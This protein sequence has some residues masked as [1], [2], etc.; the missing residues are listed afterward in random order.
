MPPVPPSDA[1]RGFTLLE[2]LVAVAILG[3][4]LT[5]ILSS[6]VGLFASASRG[7]HITVATN[8]A[9][10][11]MSELEVD[12]L[13]KGYPVT[14]MH[15]EGRCCG[16]DSEPGYDCAWKIERVKLP[17]QTLDGG[18]DASLGPLGALADIG[19]SK[20]RAGGPGSPG[21]NPLSALTALS[22]PMGSDGGPPTLQG[23]AQSLGSASS[24]GSGLGPMVMGMVYPSLKPM[25]EASIRK[26]SVQVKWKEGIK[27]KELAVTQYLTD[28]Q[29]GG[30]DGDAGTMD[31][32]ALN[33]LLGGGLG[34]PGQVAAPGQP[35][36]PT[37]PS[38]TGAR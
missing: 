14:D 23:I 18:M 12:L 5:M 30:L 36:T 20:P 9:R 19:A 16:D 3:L 10:C 34:T 37:T 28:P 38:V 17:D 1:D 4:G 33:S 29:Q 15:D 22:N 8:L 35:T 6:Q 21:S 32:G 7:E 25:L 26:V 31:G 11:K 13:R 27:E 24:A 2:V